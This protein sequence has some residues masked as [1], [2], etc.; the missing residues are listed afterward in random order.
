MRE[1]ERQI[2]AG[3]FERTMIENTTLSPTLKALV[4]ATKT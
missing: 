1:L 3:F 2:S 4:I